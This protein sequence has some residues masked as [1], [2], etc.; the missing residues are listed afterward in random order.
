M[1]VESGESGASV[2][3]GEGRANRME[4]VSFIY[5]ER[6]RLHW[7]GQRRGKKAYRRP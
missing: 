3:D 7:A 5:L 2:M 1:H 6:Q 4:P